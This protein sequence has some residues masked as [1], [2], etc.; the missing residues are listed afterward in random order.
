[1]KDNYIYFLEKTS[2]LIRKLII[3]QGTSKQRLRE[4]EI[5]INLSLSLPVLDDLE[6]LRQKIRNRLF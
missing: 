2:T 4:W 1:M 5:E 3:G 6:Q